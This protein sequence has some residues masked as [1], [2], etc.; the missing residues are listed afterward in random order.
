MH[1]KSTWSERSEA[2][3]LTICTVDTLYYYGVTDLLSGTC[4]RHVNIGGGVSFSPVNLV[5]RTC[6]GPANMGPF[7]NT[8]LRYF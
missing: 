2:R 3:C 5:S 8:I 6:Q 7:G 1:M 4:Q